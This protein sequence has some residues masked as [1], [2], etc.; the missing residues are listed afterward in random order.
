[1]FRE[2]HFMTPKWTMFAVNSHHPCP[3]METM[4]YIVDNPK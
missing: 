2:L 1:M 4:E 3:W